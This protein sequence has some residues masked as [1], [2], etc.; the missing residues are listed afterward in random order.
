MLSPLFVVFM[1]SHLALLMR[2]T[3]RGHY[4]EVGSR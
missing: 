2:L 1:E 4:D 3:D